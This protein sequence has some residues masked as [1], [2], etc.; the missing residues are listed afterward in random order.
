MKDKVEFNLSVSSA[1]LRVQLFSIRALLAK[2]EETHNLCLNLFLSAKQQ[3]KGFL[4]EPYQLL[5]DA[6]NRHFQRREE[7]MNRRGISA[8][9]K[10]SIWARKEEREAVIKACLNLGEMSIKLSPEY[11]QD[12]NRWL[13]RAYVECVQLSCA[14]YLESGKPL[15]A[16]T[17]SIVTPRQIEEIFGANS[18]DNIA[19]L[20]D[21]IQ[22]CHQSWE[23]KYWIVQPLHRPKLS[24]LAAMTLAI[25]QTAELASKRG[26]D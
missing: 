26:R 12:A 17:F 1:W 2:A 14:K 19:T 4:I 6:V 3:D 23:L 16:E 18:P 8:D 10:F 20:F 5:G 24:L 21:I 22:Q 25:E 7:D 11:A 9:K 15:F 13:A